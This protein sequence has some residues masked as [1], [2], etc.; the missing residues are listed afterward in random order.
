MLKTYTCK[1]CKKDFSNSNKLIA[2]SR[3]CTLNPN[4]KQNIDQIHSAAKLGLQKY[5]EKY[6]NLPKISKL[7]KC[8]QCGKEFSIEYT[9]IQLKRRKKFPRFCSIKCSKLY[10]H[11]FVDRQK[12]S[13]TLKAKNNIIRKHICPK[14]GKEFEDKSLSTQKFCPSCNTGIITTIKD[15][16]YT[17]SVC[18]ICGKSFYCKHNKKITCS[19]ECY[20]KLLSKKVQERIKNGTHKGWMSRKIISYPEKFFMTVL[21]NNNI[22]YKHNYTVHKKDLGINE[23]SCYFL[24]FLLENKFDLEIDGDQHKF[25]K[26]SDHKRD[27][28]LTKNGYTVYRIPWNEINSE[29][30]KQQMKQKIDDFLDFYNKRK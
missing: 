1:F 22:E 11:K 16:K 17:D 27:E 19:D 9:E 7:F 21:K 28:L 3:F 10:A 6:N 13:D 12:V 8:E 14:C 15:K 24:D 20:R 4:Y 2:H 25:R 30:G 26:D 23:A 18:V 5:I 29:N